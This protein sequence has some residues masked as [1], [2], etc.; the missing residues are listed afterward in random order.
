MASSSVQL[1]ESHGFS[2]HKFVFPSHIHPKGQS[3]L[4]IQVTVSHGIHILPSQPQSG[5]LGQ[6]KGESILSQ[7]LL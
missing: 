2:L 7:S 4:V 6:Y 1:S 3:S 5:I